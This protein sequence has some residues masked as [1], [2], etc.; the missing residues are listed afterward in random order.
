MSERIVITRGIILKYPSSL[1]NRY[2]MLKKIPPIIESEKAK[3]KST[4]INSKKP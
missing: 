1:K 4:N 3:A 2:R